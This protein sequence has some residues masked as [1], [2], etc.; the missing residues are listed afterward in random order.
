MSSTIRDVAEE[1][2]V[3]VATVSRVLNGSDN[4]REATRDRVLKAASDLDYH[5]SETARSL[6]TQKTCTVGVLLPNIHGEFFAQVTRGLDRRAQKNGHHLLVSNSHTDESEAESVIRSLL[7]RVDGLIILWPR[8]TADFLESIVPKDLPVVL[9]NTFTDRS[10]FISLSFDNRSGAY[11]AVEHLAEHGHERVAIF[12]GGAENFDAQERLAGYRMAV[13]DLG[14]VADSALEIEGDFTQEGGQALVDDFLS[15]EPRPTALF[16]SNDSMAIGALRGLHQA[17]L[18]VPEDVAL[19]G[20]D[21][22]PTAKYVTPSLTTIHAP[23]LEL[24]EQ[25]MSQLLAGLRE[26]PVSSNR[27]LETEFVARESCG[28]SSGE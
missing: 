17:G 22:I 26:E 11:T 8:I 7:G 5:P 9:L 1:A 23:T 24:G 14:L 13:D 27:T 12:T 19:V 10:R 28:C 6:R 25:A 18:Q 16:A 15:L 3:S 2:D 20:F 21:D 4:V